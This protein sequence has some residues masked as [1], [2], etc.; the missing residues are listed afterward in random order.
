M[1]EENI[2][3][4]LRLTNRQQHQIEGLRKD[5][6]ILSQ[7]VT[8]YR[9]VLEVLEELLEASG[10]VRCDQLSA[11][12]HRRR[13]EALLRKGGSD[14]VSTVFS[15]VVHSP[16]VLHPILQFSGIRCMRQVASVARI[17]S[18]SAEV[19]QQ[20]AVRPTRFYF[21]G[22]SAAGRQPLETVVRL[23][24]APREWLEMP[25]MP[26]ARDVLAAAA[27]DKDIYAVGGTDGERP[28]ASCEVYNTE[29]N[30]WSVVQNMPTPRGGLAAVAVNGR[31]YTVG[32]S[33]GERARG[34]VERYDPVTYQWQKGPSLLTPRRGVA[35]AAVGKHLYAIGGSDGV[36]TLASMERFDTEAGTA[37][38]PMPAMPT[39]RRA[40]AAAAFRGMIYVVGGAGGLH[41][42]DPSLSVLERFSLETLRWESLPPMPLA[43]RG[44]SL[45]V[46]DS[47]LYAIGGSDGRTTFDAIECFDPESLEW[48]TLSP[49]PEARGYFGAAV[50]STVD[51]LGLTVGAASWG[52]RTAR[53]SRN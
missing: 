13:F 33:D 38:E 23:E 51:F 45:L 5:V 16:G 31:L 53:R 27:I 22:G 47:L 18:H 19:S 7:T 6:G 40:G 43:R 42:Q 39:P 30:K 8:G 41:S 28:F 10:I 17:F 29:T 21:M 12:L 36:E 2:G 24:L 9:E 50:A 48:E 20:F 14:Q 15:D 32:G 49:M 3:R 11:R 35:V 44:L 26:T 34:T 46:A 25:P 4:L 52:L 37:W 1:V